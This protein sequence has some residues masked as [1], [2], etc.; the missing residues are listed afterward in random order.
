MALRALLFLLVSHSIFAGE[1]AVL[2]TGTRLHADRH[3]VVGAKVRLYSGEGYVELEADQV[4][5]FEPE[6]RAEPETI[7]PQLAPPILSPAQLADRAA[8][9]Y[10]LPRQLVRSVMSAES[11]FQQQA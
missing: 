3:E 2:T 6:E 4:N 8:D 11:G 10:G 1:Y 7:T 9:K 5:G